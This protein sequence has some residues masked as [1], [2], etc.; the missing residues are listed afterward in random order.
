LAVTSQ[1]PA[2]VWILGAWAV[3]SLP[4]LAVRSFRWEEGNYAVMARDM[5]TR[6]D[7]LEPTIFGL[8]WAEK[9]ALLAWLIAGTARL[10]G[11]VDEWSARLFPLLAILATPL[12]VQRL[13]RRDAA[14]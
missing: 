10:T 4:N 6:G 11:T 12:P 5:L 3:A 7:L 2:W 13:P 8:R 9:P 1:V 14:R